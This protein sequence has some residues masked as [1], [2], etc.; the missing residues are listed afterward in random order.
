M[1]FWQKTAIIFV[2][3][4]PDKSIV[5]FYLRVWQFLRNI[6]RKIILIKYCFY[7]VALNGD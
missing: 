3:L 2:F 6:G 5:M 7:F 1:V 4:L